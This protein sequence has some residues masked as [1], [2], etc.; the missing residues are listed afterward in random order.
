MCNTVIAFRKLY[1]VVR[2]FQDSLYH[3]KHAF[4]FRKV[5]QWVAC[6]LV[7]VEARA[8][9]AID[10]E[11]LC[12]GR[13]TFSSRYSQMSYH[14]LMASYS[15]LNQFFYYDASQ[16]NVWNIYPVASSPTLS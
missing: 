5:K 2:D 12:E 3:H 7:S 10:V 16:S 13:A 11:V 15:P 6:L 4:Y 14:V 8:V 9:I 1:L